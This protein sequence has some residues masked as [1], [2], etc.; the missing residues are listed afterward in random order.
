MSTLKFYYSNEGEVIDN[1]LHF[2]FDEKDTK[3][4]KKNNE[5]RD[6]LSFSGIII[7]GNRVFA[8]FPKHYELKDKAKPNEDIKLLLNTIMKHYKENKGLYFSRIANLETNY[9]FEAF[10]NIYDYYHKFGMFNEEALLIGKNYSG[11]ISWKKTIKK[12]TKVVSKRGLLFLPIQTIKKTKKYVFISKCMAYAIDYTLKRFQLFF[13]LP[14]VGRESLKYD[15]F[16]NK[17][18]VVVE[19]KKLKSKV[20]KDN[21][22]KL[23]IDLICFFEQ[24]PAGDT[25]YLKHYTFSMVWEKTVENYLNCCFIGVSPKGLLFDKTQKVKN[26]FRKKTFHPNFANPKQSIQPDHYFVKNKEQYIFDSKYY[27][28]LEQL[29]Y[30]QIVYYFFLSKLSNPKSLKIE[31]SHTYNALILPGSKEQKVHFKFYPEYNPGE[32]NF[33]IYEYYLDVRSAME[34]YICEK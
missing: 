6:V 20:F 30:K 18:R 3:V 33:I 9:P 19:L 11:R 13:H 10:F 12:S 4:I 31:Y 29:D 1:N 16:H 5:N 8:S 7:E 34:L 26:N 28:K 17:N 22:R 24:L 32:H 27:T 2:H 14:L 15:F 25:Y 23:L 21:D